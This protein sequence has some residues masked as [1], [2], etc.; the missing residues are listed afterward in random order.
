MASRGGRIERGRGGTGAVAVGVV[1]ATPRAV[2]ASYVARSA[3]RDLASGLAHGR[4]VL[5]L[6]V[7]GNV[8]G[9]L[10]SWCAPY[11]ERVRYGLLGP[12][13]ATREGRRVRLGGPK[14]RL[15]L[16][17]LLIEPGHWRSAD[18]LIEDTWNDDAPERARHALQAYISRLR[19]LIDDDIVSEHSGYRLDAEAD[20]V[21]ASRFEQLAGAGRGEL[22]AGLAAEAAETLR[23]ALECWR[24]PPFGDLAFEP[25]LRAE[26]TRL[27]EMRVSCVADRVEADLLLGRHVAV[28]GELDSLCREYPY[29]ERLRG[30]HMRA[31]SGAGRS[32]DALLVF[33][34]TRATFV[35]DLGLEPSAELR[36]LEYEILTGEGVADTSPVNV[37]VSEPAAVRG[38]ELRGEVRSMGPVR[39]VRAFQRV[40]GRD[41]MLRITGPEL[42]N[43]AAFVAAFEPAAEAVATVEHPHLLS[44]DDYWRDRTGAFAAWRWLHGGPLAPASVPDP[45]IFV[46]QVGGALDALHR[47]GIVHGDVGVESILTDLD[48]Q[49]F[50]SPPW[51]GPSPSHLTKAA[52][53]AG[54]ATVAVAVLAQREPSSDPSP[55]ARQQALHRPRSRWTSCCG[56]CAGAR[57]RLIDPKPST[58]E[59]AA[60][61][62]PYKGLRAF[63]ESDAC[64]FHGRERL[65][66]QLVEAVRRHRLAGCGRTER[67]R[68]VQCRAGRAA[69]PGAPGSAPGRA[70]ADHRHAPGPGAVRGVGGRLFASRSRWARCARRR[71]TVE[72]V[73]HR[74]GGRGGV[75]RRLFAAPRGGPVRGTVL[76]GH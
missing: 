4:D 9:G 29:D 42:A 74:R 70:V 51:L 68:Q 40:P 2:A 75:A 41:V 28:V 48:G 12:V 1:L 21:D 37:V 53:L 19:G 36:R 67:N 62:N 69:S 72:R 8:I 25:A 27:G 45:V 10:R 34:K 76:D 11:G 64:D 63:Q 71:I 46:E 56:P 3:C 6:A 47:R 49:A 17:L 60:V 38:Y 7:S 5:E 55:W 31:L 66:D 58:A 22:A 57:W 61:R 20:A 43:A 32:R 52:D 24:G 23:E 65:T 14:Q 35:E 54:L 33:A 59:P 18:R 73:R 16:A 44:L 13:E 50:L 26:A 15:V 39:W 30:L